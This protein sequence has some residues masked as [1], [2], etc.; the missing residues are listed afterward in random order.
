MWNAGILLH[1]TL[2]LSLSLSLGNFIV[3]GKKSY[4]ILPSSNENGWH[5]QYKNRVKH[6]PTSYGE[7]KSIKVKNQRASQVNYL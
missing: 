6:G 7:N 3:V 2:S 5:C 1:T 4:Y